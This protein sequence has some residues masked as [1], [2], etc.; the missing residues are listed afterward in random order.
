[1][2]VGLASDIELLESLPLD[3]PAFAERQHRWIRGDWQIGAWALGAVLVGDG[4]LRRNP[5]SILNRWRILDNLR[6]KSGAGGLAA[7]AGIRNVLLR[8]SGVWS[9][10]LG[11]AIVVPALVPVLDRWSRHLEGSV[12]GWQGAADD[13]KRAFVMIAFLPHQ[14]WLS[15]DAIIR[16]LHRKLFSKLNLLEW[17]TADAA[18]ERTPVAAGGQS[19]ADADHL[20]DCGS[21]LAV[22]RRTWRVP[23][24]IRIPWLVDR[25]AAARAVAGGSR[26]GYLDTS[27]SGRSE[28]AELRQLAR[29]TWRYFDDLVGPQSHWLPPDNSQLALRV[30]VA[31][32]TSPTNIGLWLNSALAARDFGYITTDDF[33]RRCSATMETLDKMERYEG[34]FLNW[35]DLDDT[36]ATAAA[37][38][39]DRG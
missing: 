5:L 19:A 29:R 36:D 13:L 34:H 23:V 4:Q 26:Q 22:A 2:G 1:M 11:V 3:Y 27:R 33:V 7:A 38:C 16:V 12:Y 20:R 17:K 24:F 25:L 39:L 6:Q 18:E 15:A 9:I 32:R 30:E 8:C 14:A 28:N 10:L 21:A 37:I 35:Y 31:R